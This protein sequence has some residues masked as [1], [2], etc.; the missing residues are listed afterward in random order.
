MFSLINP[1]DLEHDVGKS[2]FAL[3][4]IRRSFEHAYQLL[5]IALQSQCD[6]QSSR[7]FPC[8]P[9]RNGQ[10]SVLCM[11]IRGDDPIINA[12]VKEFM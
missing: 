12:R 11:A 3:P 9:I 4:R 1:C 6:C 10:G 7:L 5:S 2:C 8:N